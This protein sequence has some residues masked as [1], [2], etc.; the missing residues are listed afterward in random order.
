MTSPYL[1]NGMLCLS[2]P[3]S[4]QAGAIFSSCKVKHW[5][6]QGPTG[7]ILLVGFQL[8]SDQT[9]VTLKWFFLSDPRLPSHGL[10][11]PPLWPPP[12]SPPQAA[13]KNLEPQHTWKQGSVTQIS[14]L[15]RIFEHMLK[16]PATIF[17]EFLKYYSQYLMLR[18]VKFG[19]LFCFEGGR[20]W[21]QG[22]M[23]ARQMHLL[24]EPLCQPFFVIFFLPDRVSWS[25]CFGWF[26][27]TVL[28]ISAS[29]VARIIGVSHLCPVW[30]SVFVSELL[31]L[32]S[33]PIWLSCVISSCR[34][35]HRA[36]RG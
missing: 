6:F 21:T 27:T 20:V 9:L 15:N 16:V 13:A 1:T 5:C 31:L 30:L 2:Q 11:A 7:W 28:L 10:W 12:L 8:C 4:P 34:V 23:L 26:Q 22:L 25:I 19:Y 18:D 29:W 24:L 3:P 14:S 32:L 17:L 35:G 36:S 33:A